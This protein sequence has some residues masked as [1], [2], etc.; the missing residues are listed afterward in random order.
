MAASQV[1]QP[2]IVQFLLAQGA[3]MHARGEVSTCSMASLSIFVFVGGL[4]SGS[5]YT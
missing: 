4:F 2:E 1:A 5:C 3:D